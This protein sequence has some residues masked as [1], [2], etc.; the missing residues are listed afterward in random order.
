MH[1]L[2]PV[3][4]FESFAAWGRSVVTLW[5]PHQ[6]QSDMR[7]APNMA[8]RQATGPHSVP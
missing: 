3:P 4:D 8:A 6:S 5:T 7:P 1:I 2:G